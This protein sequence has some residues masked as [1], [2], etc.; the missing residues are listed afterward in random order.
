MGKAVRTMN[1]RITIK[2]GPLQDGMRLDVLA[3]SFAE[4][5]SRS[6]VRDA[7]KSGALTV[8][9]KVCTTPGRKI[10]PGE[11]IVLELPALQ[12][13][14]LPEAED[15][16]LDIVYEDDD[17]IVIDKPR[18]MVVHP[19]AG[20]SSGTLV[21][22]LLAH[23]G[24]SIR[25]LGDDPERPGIVHRIDKDTS[26]LLVCAKS[27][28]AFEGLKEQFSRHSIRREYFAIVHHNIK[29]ECGTVDVP[30]GRHPVNGARR[31]VNGKDARQAVTHYKVLERLGDYCLISCRLETGRTHQI[32]VH[33][34]HIGHPVAGDPLYGPKKDRLGAGGQIL[35]AGV[36]GF[37]HP[38][39]GEEMCFESPL[40]EYFE[41]I[42]ER[43]RKKEGRA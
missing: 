39:T 27:P 18:G 10:K 35:H 6:A 33:M 11:V 26:G 31:S 9:G 22:A 1:S 38:V 17:L 14:S 4:G 37:T 2:A 15:I 43:L 20:N 5:A 34:A 41:K 42:L 19:G 7:I 32:R 24:E 21:N 13:E 16:P 23:V 25:G 30:L 29:E 28:A 8:D 12:Q 40:P 3:A 36:L